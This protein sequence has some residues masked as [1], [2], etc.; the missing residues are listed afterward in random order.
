MKRRDMV[1]ATASVMAV[2]GIAWCGV[3]LAGHNDDQVGDTYTA[4]TPFDSAGDLRLPLDG[5]VP[6]RQEALDISRARDSLINS[7][8]DRFTGKAYV[9][10]VA[11]GEAATFSPYRFGLV[12]SASAAKFGYH[13]P[14]DDN[15]P[16][17]A[18]AHPVQMPKGVA[19]P[20]WILN[21]SVPDGT[22]RPRDPEHLPLPERGCDGEANALLG[23]EPASTPTVQR[24]VDTILQGERGDARV[25]A[26]MSKWSDCMSEKGYSYKNPLD[27]L[28]EFG[29]R[30]TLREDE[31]KTAT[32]DADCRI[33]TAYVET[34]TA[35]LAE[36]QSASLAR[37]PEAWDAQRDWL[38]ARVKRAHGLAT[39]DSL[40][41]TAEEKARVSGP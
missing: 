8:V 22:S 39:L 27:P 2:G 32:D 30:T 4:A 25:Q 37:Q 36:L 20:R 28:L 5:F 11:V 21:G 13:D 34:R 3:I 31:L 38:A 33:E 29:S 6:T 16:A 35:V 7:C 23:Q 18:V 1:A 17:W 19:T 24:E 40:S 41:H 26:A 12:G 15:S 10:E 9:P 14:Q